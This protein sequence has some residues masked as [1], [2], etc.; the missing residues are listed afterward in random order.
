MVKCTVG[1]QLLLGNTG[2][3]EVIKELVRGRPLGLRCEDF[4]VLKGNAVEVV[5]SR[6]QQAV[7]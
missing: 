6:S 3:D 5:F 4:S 7:S 2:L 1:F